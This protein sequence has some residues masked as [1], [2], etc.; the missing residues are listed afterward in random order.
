MTT[1]CMKTMYVYGIIVIYNILCH[2]RELNGGKAIV[3]YIICYLTT[4]A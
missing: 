2:N 4:V 3:L 1:D